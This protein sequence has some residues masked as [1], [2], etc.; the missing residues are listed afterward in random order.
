MDFTSSWTKILRRRERD[1]NNTGS[2]YLVTWQSHEKNLLCRGNA[3]NAWFNL[4]P[5]MVKPCAGIASGSLI[6]VEDASSRSRIVTLLFNARMSA[7]VRS[8]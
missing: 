2:E 7:S 1:V 3:T 5:V 8:M 6:H 4:K